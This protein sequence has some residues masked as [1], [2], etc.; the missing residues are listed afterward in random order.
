MELTQG[1][2]TNLRQLGPAFSDMEADATA[3]VVQA[4]LLHLKTL[5]YA[6]QFDQR[7]VCP[8]SP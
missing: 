8:C 3:P 7:K 2:W 6:Q 5:K 1:S 4:Q